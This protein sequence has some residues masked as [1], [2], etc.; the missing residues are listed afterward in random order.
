MSYEDEL[1]EL[2]KSI[3]QLRMLVGN[4]EE[5]KLE[6]TDRLYS[7]LCKLIDT[8]ESEYNMLLEDDGYDCADDDD[9]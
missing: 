7:D 8:Y 1:E 6:A 4:I 9:D 5:Y 2:E 3:E